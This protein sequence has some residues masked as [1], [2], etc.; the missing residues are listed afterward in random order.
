M[1]S[2][3]TVELFI[4]FVGL[5][6]VLGMF[7]SLQGAH[8]KPY[9]WPNFSDGDADFQ[10]SSNIEQWLAS[11]VHYSKQN[12][13]EVGIVSFTWG[14][15]NNDVIN[16]FF[17]NS[18]A[19]LNSLDPALTFP[20]GDGGNQVDFEDPA[21]ADLINRANFAPEDSDRITHTKIIS[22]AEREC[23]LSTSNWT[24]GG[25]TAQPNVIMHMNHS[26]VCSGA[27]SEIKEIFNGTNWDNDIQWTVDNTGPNGENI[28]LYFY[29]DVKGNIPE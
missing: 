2:Q 14:T 22:L 1:I 12:N 18:D 24:T 3:R 20:T 19:G 15:G 5:L 29:P 8:A 27:M 9:A 26:G 25:Y 17:G 13:D 7:W 28:E 4:V 10:T 21:D 6:F 23:I 11:F 16:G